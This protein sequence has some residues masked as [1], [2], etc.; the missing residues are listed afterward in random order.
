MCVCVCLV[1]SCPVRLGGNCEDALTRIGRVPVSLLPS[2]PALLHSEPALDSRAFPVRAPLLVA[3]AS[4]WG[5]L[6]K[7]RPHVVKS[8]WT[9]STTYSRQYASSLHSSRSNIHRRYS[10]NRIRETFRLIGSGVAVHAQI[11]TDKYSI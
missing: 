7:Q 9:C 5:R 10:P 8:R 6:R 2:L 3:P 1:L 11:S 4:R